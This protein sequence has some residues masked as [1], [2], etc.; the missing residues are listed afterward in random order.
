M[1][2]DHLEVLLLA[3]EG[4]TVAQSAE[5]MQCSPAWV[6]RL[7]SQLCLELGAANITQA[8][9]LAYHRKILH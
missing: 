9:A 3:T 4:K 5:Q 6:A 8:V 2:E 1:T 7:R